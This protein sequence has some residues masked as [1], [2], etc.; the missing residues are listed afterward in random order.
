MSKLD[1][2]DRK[3]LY[4]L[5]L[6]SRQ[7]DNEIAK[8]VNLSRDSV[9]YRIKK[10]EDEGYINYSV[11]ILNSMKLGFQWYRTFFKFHNLNLETETRI[12]EWLK[13][14]V[15][16]IVKVEGKWDLNMAIFC[17]NVYEYRDFINEFILNFSEYIYKYEVSVVTRM[18]IYNKKWL[19][20]KPMHQNKIM[21]GYNEKES[22]SKI[23]IDEIDYK[24]LKE[25]LKNGREKTVN[26]SRKLNLTEMIVRYRMRK[27]IDSGIIIGFRPFF[28]INKFGY[29][30][31][32]LHIYLH[33]I[34]KDKKQKML[35]YFHNHQNTVYLTELV[36]GADIEVEYQ[37]KSNEEFYKNIEK[38]KLEFGD[39]IRTYEFM[40][41]TKEFK[42]TYLPEMF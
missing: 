41:Y 8:K 37:V 15:S 39:I 36:G 4:E 25:L 35:S 38:L 10:F 9:R 2:K 22:Y 21:M 7:S 11:T 31:F 14:R 24:I 18:W 5:D 30:Y 40:Q 20:E 12:I 3:I 6:D 33:N 16:W 34:T 1:L 28:N 19:L 29:I 23:N 42:F 27:M 17:T 13:K 32:K 26:I